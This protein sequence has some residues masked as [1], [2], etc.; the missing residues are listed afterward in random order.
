SIGWV[1]YFNGR[2]QEIEIETDII[3]DIVT[4][5]I[6]HDKKLVKENILP[7][8]ID[9]DNTEIDFVNS[10]LNNI[11]KNNILLNN[12]L[13]SNNLIKLYSFDYANKR[14]KYFNNLYTKHWIEVRDSKN[15]VLIQTKYK[16]NVAWDDKYYEAK[17]IKKMVFIEDG[18]YTYTYVYKY[19]PY[20]YIALIRSIS[21]N[22]I[23][24]VFENKDFSWNNWFQETFFNV[25]KWEQIFNF[26]I[27]FFILMF[28]VPFALKNLYELYNSLNI[29]RYKNLRYTVKLKKLTKQFSEQKK[30][31][32]EQ[33][34]LSSEDIKLKEK[35]LE[36]KFERQLLTL[37]FEH[38]R[39]I[40][41]VKSGFS[42]Y[43]EH[44]EKELERYKTIIKQQSSEIQELQY[45]LQEHN[46][47]YDPY[48]FTDFKF[49][50]KADI[51]ILGGEGSISLKEAYNILKEL[52]LSHNTDIKW[53]AY[54]DMD[55]FDIT[56][57]QN[58]RN[59]S[60]IIVGSV[61][62]SM[63]NVPEQNLVSHLQNNA[64]IYPKFQILRKKD[65]GDLLQVTK[66]NLKEA[67]KRSNKY[68]QLMEIQKL[69][70]IK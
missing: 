44:T 57:L 11:N 66:S 3:F 64:S 40:T 35:E 60:D 59:Y 21:L 30:K 67:L 53:I 47:K 4:D 70:L 65:D 49:R 69:N 26:W 24:D 58:T 1:S 63:L 18:F 15:N 7:L 22:T 43:Y 36:E 20:W 13:F 19:K 48:K 9:T 50:D 31:I 61:P 33:K 54:R 34:D 10:F 68:K 12:S 38:N 51:L 39:Q 2:E 55:H 42:K 41:S 14:L 27:I 17:K 52:G 37:K 25:G 62:H 56:A 32:S 29:L 8:N 5:I 23:P 46:I 16:N 28:I 45:S 6:K